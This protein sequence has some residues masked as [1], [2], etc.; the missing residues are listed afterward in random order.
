[1]RTLVLGDVHGCLDEMLRLVERAALGPD[2]QLV[3]VGDLVDRGPRSLDVVRFF[4]ADP[5]RRRAVLGNHEE[6]HLRGDRTEQQDPSGRVLRREVTAAEYDEMRRYFATLPLWLDLPEALV[7]HAGLEPGTAL[8]EQTP[9]VL[10]GRGSQGRTGF[11]GQSPWWFED[12]AFAWPK[13]V[14]FGHQIFP[15]VARGPTGRVW[16]LDTGAAVGGRLTGLL[17]P[18]F[19]LLAEPTPDYWAAALARWRPVFL[20]E[21]LPDLPWARVS[22]LDPAAWPPALAE[23]IRA[24]QALLGAATARLQ[25]EV[26]ALVRATGYARLSPDERAALSRQLRLEPRFQSPWS[27]CVLRC[28]PSGD[29]AALLRKRF[30]TPRELEAALADPPAPRGE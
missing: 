22:A 13:P 19:E 18:S 23:R 10:T 26:A 7:V 16:G 8:A 20:A 30:P 27:A 25:A 2:D 14:V 29:T 11:D 6:K 21:D 1:M 15:E 9:K 17:L 12:P 5:E 4:A 3:A 28:F 24:P